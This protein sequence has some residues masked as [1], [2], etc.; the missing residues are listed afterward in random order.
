MRNPRFT[1]ISGLRV[2]GDSAPLCYRFRYG[3]QWAAP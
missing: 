1:L 2:A 3:R